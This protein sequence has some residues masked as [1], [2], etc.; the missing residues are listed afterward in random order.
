MTYQTEFFMDLQFWGYFAIAVL[1]YRIVPP[2][3]AVKEWLLLACSVCML[4]ALP[5]FTLSMLAVLFV[6][7]V[8]THACVRVLIGDAGRASDRVRVAAAGAGIF[9]ILCALVFFKYGFVQQAILRRT[10]APGSEAAAVIFLIG[11]SYS[12]FKAM[13]VVIEAYKG[14][15]KNLKFMTFL[16]YMLFFPSFL[17]GPINRYSHYC[18]N[19]ADTRASDFRADLAAGTERIVHGLF[20]KVVLT[21]ALLPYTLRN[22]TVPIQDMPTWQIVAGLY[23]YALYFYLDF[24]GYT[25]LALGSA[26]IMGFV[27]PENFDFPFL[28]RNIQQLWANWHMSLTSWLTDYVYWPLA[29]KLR[30]VG[31]LRKRPVLLSNVAIVVTFLGCGLWHGDTLSFLLWGLYHGLGIAAVTTYQSW[32]RRVRDPRARAY[33]GSVY[34]RVIGTVVTFNFFAVGLLPFALDF[35]Q[36]QTLLARLV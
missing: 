21:M 24:S 7:C 17:S 5:R 34:S 32:K 29:R 33:F 36:I 19:S 1:V 18:E 4:L 23:V 31:Y 8:V 30:N 16:N 14:D 2:R 3:S 35:N 27:L 26:R 28:K 9:V 11:I 10:P 25:D 15:L 22:L 13:H 20:K 6:L 12:S